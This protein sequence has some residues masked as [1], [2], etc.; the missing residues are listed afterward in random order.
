MFFSQKELSSKV[1]SIQKNIQLLNFF[2]FVFIY[3]IDG[4]I[5]NGEFFLVLQR[6]VRFWIFIFDCRSYW[7]SY[8]YLKEQVIYGLDDIIL[9][10]VKQLLLV[11]CFGKS[12]SL[13]NIIFYQVNLN[14]W[15]FIYLDF[16]FLNLSL[17]DWFCLLGRRFY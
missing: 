14:L 16:V 7:F 11:I 8:F 2:L 3:S 4:E 1:I 5:C 17:L 6:M 12:M 13:E 15:S 9:Y 10:F